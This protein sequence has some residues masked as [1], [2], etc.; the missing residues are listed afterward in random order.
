MVLII[1]LVIENSILLIL[2]V[3]RN[4]FLTLCFKLL[5]LFIDFRQSADC[6]KFH[7]LGKE[8]IL[9]CDSLLKRLIEFVLNLRVIKLCPTGKEISEI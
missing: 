9:S 5:M 1:F 6:S 3:F 8:N 2:E 4:V 7:V